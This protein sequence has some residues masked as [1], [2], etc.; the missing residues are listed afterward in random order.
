[1]RFLHAVVGFGLILGSGSAVQAVEPGAP[2]HLLNPDVLVS[3]LLEERVAG[4]KAGGES[5]D[6]AAIKS[7]YA[8][9]NYQPLWITEGRMGASA[10]SVVEEIAQADD[11]GLEAEAFDLPALDRSGSGL[12]AL[13][14]DE[15]LLTRTVLKYA[16]HARGG[17]I[18]PRSLS[19]YLDRGP[20]LVAPEKVLTSVAS[21]DTPDAYL[22]GL[23]PQHEEFKRLRARYLTLRDAGKSEK[24]VKIPSGPVLA[25]GKRHPHVALL[26]E[27]LKIP[28]PV[29]EVESKDETAAASVDAD[30]AEKAEERLAKRQKRALETF[31]TVMKGAVRSFQKKNGL[32][33]DGVVGAGT[34][35]ALN[36]DGVDQKR[37]LLVNME[38]WRWMPDDLANGGDMYVWANIP[39]YRFYVIKNGEIIHTERVVVGKY[40]N[41]TATF[42]DEMEEIVFNPRW[43]VPQSIKDRELRS[44]SAIMRQGLRVK[45]GGRYVDP[46]SVDWSTA[47]MAKYHVYQ[48]SGP[49][50]ALGKL[51]F[52]FPNKHAIYM[53]DTPSKR[54]FKRTARAFSHGCVRV[55]DPQR[56]AEVILAADQGFTMSDVRSRI[57][58][59]A[60]NSVFLKRKL[61]VHIT[62]FTA[63]ADGEDASNVRFMRDIYRHDKRIEQALA[64]N[65]PKYIAQNSL[66]PRK[67][68]RRV[69][70]AR[71]KKQP[72]WIQNI[73]GLN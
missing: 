41:Q 15:L 57:R 16:V 60:R 51:K 4:L 11:Y 18:D 25:L 10:R 36:G 54:L 53:H 64:G 24:L 39:D 3:D 35:R 34:R 13:V 20:N 32:K 68:V 19:A 42:S 8:S 40:Q 71:K 31:D 70:T 7:F 29:V 38:R 67:T 62:Y 43:N 46:R 12:K 48:P 63:R 59:G 5:T 55:R 44:A 69:Q 6:N 23:H 56:F 28:A 49:R 9:R 65:P 26:R 73:F 27:R 50:N 61:P 21:T 72:F 22:R 37:R 33:V 30:A 47:N 1:M 45:R 17:R 52:L 58:S 66:S 2:G 14:S